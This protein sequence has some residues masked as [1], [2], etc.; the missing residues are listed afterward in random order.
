ML[1]VFRYEPLE[2]AAPSRRPL[3]CS[4]VADRARYAIVDGV[5]EGSRTVPFKNT[6]MF[7]CRV[8]TFTVRQDV[9]IED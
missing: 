8:H 9:R 7:Q 4:G 5:A 1:F 2:V 6:A 3:R